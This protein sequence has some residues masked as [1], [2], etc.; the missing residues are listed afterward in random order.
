MFV[1][2]LHTHT[3]TFILLQMRETNGRILQPMEC[4]VSFKNPLPYTSLTNCTVT[5]EGAGFMEAQRH[6]PVV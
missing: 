2:Y 4:K 6:M 1:Y 3:I 5:L